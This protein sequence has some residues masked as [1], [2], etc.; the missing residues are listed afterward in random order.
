MKNVAKRRQRYI[1]AD[2]QMKK[3]KNDIGFD[4]KTRKLNLS[5][6]DIE[7]EQSHIDVFNEYIN[8]L[9]QTRNMLF[10]LDKNKMKEY[11]LS[12][13]DIMPST[14][15]LA[16]RLELNCST[17]NKWQAREKTKSPE[18]NELLKEFQRI[19]HGEFRQVREQI[20]TI[21]MLVGII[22][23]QSGQFFLKY[24][25]GYKDTEIEEMIKGEGKSITVN[26][27]D[28]RSYKKELITKDI[29]NVA[30]SDLSSEEKVN[31][32]DEL[33]KQLKSLES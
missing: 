14:L 5:F 9:L 3:L 15:S 32:I 31:K 12:W 30:K 19:Y 10:D 28:A 22:P 18:M 4:Q 25:F 11:R 27:H 17:V 16:I 20:L 23:S 24:N 8:E 33:E 26:Y 29:I 21:G 2:K 7:I 13:A 6:R 1:N